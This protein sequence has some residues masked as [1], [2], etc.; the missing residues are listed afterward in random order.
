MQ[1]H[2]TKFNQTNNQNN[3]NSINSANLISSPQNSKATH[4]LSY[5][6]QGFFTHQQQ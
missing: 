3:I 5:T 1:T 4:I 6:S 2:M